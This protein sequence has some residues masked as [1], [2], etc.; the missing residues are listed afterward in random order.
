MLS[1]TSYSP[2]TVSCVLRGKQ[3]FLIKSR[4]ITADLADKMI[5]RACKASKNCTKPFN[6]PP[7]FRGSQV[8]SVPFNRLECHRHAIETEESMKHKDST[9]TIG[10]AAALCRT[11]GDKMCP[12]AKSKRNL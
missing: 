6:C 8:C 10:L 1:M 4:V 9:F 3:K 5:T 2:P 12:S 7:D 11:E